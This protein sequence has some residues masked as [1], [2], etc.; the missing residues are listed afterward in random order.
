VVNARDAM[1]EGGTL[2]M[3]TANA[4]LEEEQAARL[5]VAPGPYVTLTIQDTGIGMDEETLARV[6][7]PF[8]TTKEKGTGLGLPTVYGIVRQSGGAV[9]IQSL[10]GQGTSFRVWL[11]RLL[12]A[13]LERPPGAEAHAL[14]EGAETILVVED[15]RAVRN[16]ARRVLSA[17]GYSVLLAE[18][19]QDARSVLQGHSGRLDL[20]LTDVVMPGMKGT[21]F[22]RDLA[23]THHELKVLFMSG[24]SAPSA[25]NTGLPEWR[26]RFI[27]KPFTAEDLVRKVREVLDQ[28]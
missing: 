21:D 1:P 14:P 28:P 23:R 15:E 20:V 16:L 3:K 4:S 24:Y 10:P 11:P 25:S 26:G 12:S 22:A 17:A 27:S 5:G 9:E 2:T 6:F 18:S 7:E 13:I 19:A 8:F